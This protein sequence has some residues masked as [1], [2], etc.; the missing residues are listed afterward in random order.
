MMSLD[1]PLFSLLTVDK[2]DDLAR[3]LG[4]SRAS[5]K[6]D[7]LVSLKVQRIMVFWHKKEKQISLSIIKDE[8]F[9]LFKV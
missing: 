6:F 4:V 9:R 5:G 2:N 7:Y 8:N 1:A 3:G